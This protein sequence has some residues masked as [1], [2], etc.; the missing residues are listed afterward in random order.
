LTD[1]VPKTTTYKKLL[2][3]KGPDF[4][5]GPQIP[6]AL[7]DEDVNDEGPSN[8]GLPSYGRDVLG[9]ADAPSQNGQQELG[10]DEDVV[11]GEASHVLGAVSD[12]I[13]EQLAMEMA[14]AR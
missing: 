10:R 4:K 12:P 1:V 11:M 13:Q 5:P 8:V 14:G 9:L 2:A 7:A 3:E 6:K